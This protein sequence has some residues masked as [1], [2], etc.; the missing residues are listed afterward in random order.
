[1]QNFVV[2]ARKYRPSTWDDVV[3]QL[4]VVTTLKNAIKTNH[5]AQSFL[6]CGPRGVG[7]TTCARILAKTINCTNISEDGDACNVCQS[8][9]SFAEN[10]SFNIH[11]IDAASNN[12]I[13]DIRNLIDQ[14]R[15]APQSG[16]YKIYIIDEVHMLSTQAFNAFLKTLEEPPFYV[17]FILA[18][19]E[20]HKIIPTILSRC[21][22]FD[23]KRITVKDMMFQLKKISKNEAIKIDDDALH[24][25]AQ[26]A[27]G[28]LRDALSIFDR[29]A[30]FAGE[31]ISEKDVIENL[32]ILDYDYYFRITEACL[33][34]NASQCLLLLSEI[35]DKGFD[36]DIFL[37]G[38]AEH[39]RNLLVCKEPSTINLIEASDSVLDKYRRQ[40]EIISDAFL[41]TALS[42]LNTADV[43]YKLSKNKRLHVETALLKLCYLHHLVEYGENNVSQTQATAKISNKEKKNTENTAYIRTSVKNEQVNEPEIKNKRETE[44]VSIPKKGNLREKILLKQKE[45]ENKTEQLQTEIEENGEEV[46][47]ELFTAAWKKFSDVIRNTISNVAVV[48]DDAEWNIQ[49]NIVEVKTDTEM[50]NKWLKEIA[51]ELRRFIADMINNQTIILRFGIKEKKIYEQPVRTADKYK[52]MEEI[53]PS[54]KKIKDILGFELDY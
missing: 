26:K 12:S 6:F 37:T 43:Q 17:K 19:T 20:K 34:E 52:K 25:I 9:L 8:C 31:K 27:D 54:L 51:P 47:V 29:I 24:L 16:K 10:A 50:H 32:N 15:F 36:G 13:E 46:S 35:N 41:L 5:L 18:T 3:G 23:F 45:E 7:K 21:Q 2:S 14:V 49:N 22:I 39:L 1:M 42:L 33:S 30:S 53:N 28:A 38:F 44:T 48:M 4:S 40:S 11:E